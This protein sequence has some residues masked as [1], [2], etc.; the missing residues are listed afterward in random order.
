MP[1]SLSGANFIAYFTEENRS[2]L[3]SHYWF[4]HHFA[5]DGI[6]TLY[7]LIKMKEKSSLF[8][9]PWLLPCLPKKLVPIMEHFLSLWHYQFSFWTVSFS[10]TYR[11]SLVVQWL[12]LFTSN[13]GGVGLIPGWG[14]KIAHAAE[15]G[16]K[17]KKK[18]KA[19]IQTRFN[20][21]NLKTQNKNL[22]WPTNSFV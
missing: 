16:Q 2:A 13:A 20:I 14:T 3:S 6:H 21:S 10:L 11:T 8:L 5:S 7:I 1:G 17:W 19:D 4:Y 12:K 15:H 9:K 22:P 18:K